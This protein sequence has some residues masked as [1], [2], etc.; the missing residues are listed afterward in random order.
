[1]SVLKR[2]AAWLV[3]SQGATW[4]VSV[5]LLVVA[6]REL[7]NNAFGRMSFAMVYMAFV[8]LIGLFGTADYLTKTIA[9][10][11]EQ[12]G[13]Y[14]A[15]TLRLKAITSVALFVFRVGLAVIL[16]YYVLLSAAEALGRQGR[17]PVALALWTP[18]VALGLF[19]LA[20]FLRAASE[21]PIPGMT[22][23]SNFLREIGRRLPLARTA[24]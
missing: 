3:L 5:A 8:E 24:K 18:N 1:M 15:N 19:G 11:P 17:A 20:L 14:V 23:A 16:G 4:I 10:H 9:R 6:P 7:G 12:V 21:K 22:Q 2:N 13:R